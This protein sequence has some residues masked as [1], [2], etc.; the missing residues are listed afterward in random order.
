VTPY[1]ARLY[2]VILGLAAVYN[3][4]FGLWAAAWPFA[5]FDIFVMESPRYPSIWRCLGMVVGLYGLAYGYSALHL[6][7]ARPFVVLGLLGKVLGPVGWCL[8]VRGEEFPLRTFTLILFN[9]LVWWLPFSLFLLEGTRV[10]ERLRVSAPFACA[11]LN[12]L[13]ALALALILR[14]GTEVGGDAVAR[15]AYI[16]EHAN[17][18]RAGWGLWIA[19]ALSLCAF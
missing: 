13:S 11:A 1:R 4:G 18:W 6:D 17:V 19:A 14:P 16:Q 3:L 5:F 10:G 15:A 12:A 9:D 2:R 8:A 7:R